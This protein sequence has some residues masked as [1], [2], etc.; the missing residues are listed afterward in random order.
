MELIRTGS[1][2]KK[3][4][5]GFRSPSLSCFEFASSPRG[6][7]RHSDAREMT[8]PLTFLPKLSSQ[9]FHTRSPPLRAWLSANIHEVGG[10][11]GIIVKYLGEKGRPAHFMLR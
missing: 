1:P 8:N 2:L 3:S 6:P 10:V 4:S 9:L 7:T 11:C 5:R